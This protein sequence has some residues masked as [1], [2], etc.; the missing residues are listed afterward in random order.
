MESL[1]I[2]QKKPKRKHRGICIEIRVELSNPDL[3]PRSNFLCFANGV[4]D[5]IISLAL[6]FY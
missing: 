1:P 2:K 6:K 5:Q 4:L 3:G